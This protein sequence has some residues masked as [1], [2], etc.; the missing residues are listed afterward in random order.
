MSLSREELERLLRE[1]KDYERPGQELKGERVSTTDVLDRPLIFEDFIERESR[2]DEGTYMLVQAVDVKARKRVV[3]STRAKILREELKKA[4][5][6][7]RWP[8]KAKI[9]RLKRALVLRPLEE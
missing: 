9:V 6:E 3:F 1:A 4:K 8:L 2:Y 7:G 5:E